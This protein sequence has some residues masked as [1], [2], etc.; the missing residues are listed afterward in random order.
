MAVLGGKVA[1]LIYNIGST[2]NTGSHSTPN[3]IDWD[4]LTEIAPSYC[5]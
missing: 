2:D 5:S 3:N 1:F 4:G